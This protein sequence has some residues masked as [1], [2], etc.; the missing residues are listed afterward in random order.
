MKV[1]FRVLLV[2]TVCTA[3]WVPVI[4]VLVLFDFRSQLLLQQATEE[5]LPPVVFRLADTVVKSLEIVEN[6]AKHTAND[7]STGALVFVDTP[8][9]HQALREHWNSV[10]TAY[11]LVT[12]V[13]F[14]TSEYTEHPGRMIGLVKYKSGD[15]LWWWTAENATLEQWQVD[16]VTLRTTVL[17]FRNNEWF[18]GWLEG[19]HA[20]IPEPLAEGWEN[21]YG[22]FGQLWTSYIVHAWDPKTTGPNRTH[23]AYGNTDLMIEEITAVFAGLTVPNGVAVLV[24]TH[25]TYLLGSTSSNVPMIHMVG[26]WQ[27]AV[28]VNQSFGSSLAERSVAAMN[29]LV[30]RKW[31][32]WH[33]LPQ[34]LN[35][36]YYEPTAPERVYVEGSS[37]KY[38]VSFALVRRQC[39][40]WV[41]AVIAE[42]DSTAMDVTPIIVAIATTIGALIALGVLSFLLVQPLAMLSKRMKATAHLTFNRRESDASVFTEFKTLSD[43]FR[44]LSMGIEA[45]TKYVPMPVVSQIMSS[46]SAVAV[47]R[48]D[49]LA[50]SMRRVT[51]MFC[52]I[53][54][55]TTLSEKLE[56]TVVVRVLFDWLGAFTKVIVKNN[57][58]VDKY[59]GDCIMALWNAP[60]ETEKPDA[61]ACQ[62]ALEFADVQ[63]ALNERFAKEG[64][65]EFGVRVGI[66]SGELFVGN[67]GCED[68]INYTVCGTPANIAARIEQ[69]GKM[70]E[71]T[72]LISGDV[73]KAVQDQ[74]VCVW[75]DDTKL[76]GHQSTE[77]RD[78]VQEALNDSTMDQYNTTL[79]LLMEKLSH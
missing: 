36:E 13:N 50:V 47:P 46:S 72:P 1:S 67:I 45:M 21:I 41:V 16:P 24:D 74:F 64:L 43:S 29:A 62:S 44:K 20:D 56:T 42:E 32:N 3:V 69:L 8:E 55:F 11:S 12:D 57:G 70:Y 52:D 22:E 14:I 27:E 17:D 37:K 54:G 39:L 65:P 53:R 23:I 66:H 71:A 34:V 60:L 61:K 51:I 25:T 76:R 31:G 5:R 9:G 59:I 35:P 63:K 73:A 7:I 33:R 78:R 28:L 75:L 77:A 30:E 68:H 40:S 48:E 19:M 2:V 79:T 26:D 15:M 6:V 4:V 18:W 10:L 38:L 58:I 49:M